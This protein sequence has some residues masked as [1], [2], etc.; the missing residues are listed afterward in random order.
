MW[1]GGAAGLWLRRGVRPLAVG[2]RPPS[3]ARE[4]AATFRLLG[5]GRPSVVGEQRPFGGGGADHQR[6]KEVRRW[7]VTLSAASMRQLFLASAW[8]TH[9]VDN[10]VFAFGRPRFDGRDQQR[11]IQDTRTNPRHHKGASTQTG[12]NSSGHY[13][14]TTTDTLNQ[15]FRSSGR[16]EGEIDQV[17]TPRRRVHDASKEMWHTIKQQPKD[18][19]YEESKTHGGTTR[20]QPWSIPRHQDGPSQDAR[21]EQRRPP[22]RNDSTQPERALLWLRVCFAHVM[23]RRS[24]RHDTAAT[25]ATA[26]VTMGTSTRTIIGACIGTSSMCDAV[27]WL[28]C[29]PRVFSCGVDDGISDVASKSAQ[30]C[31]PI[32]GGSSNRCRTCKQPRASGGEKKFVLSTHQRVRNT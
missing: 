25:N 27:S 28:I 32:G 10:D 9:F 20:T 14:V 11:A 8:R 30:Q 1:G 17:L 29:D 22:R 26:G 15:H 2:E 5:S 7:P 18:V 13:K 12:S 21:V 24:A 3:H 6:A 19:R 31:A 23:S 16:H 4:E